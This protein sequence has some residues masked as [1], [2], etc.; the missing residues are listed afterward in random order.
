MR[1]LNHVDIPAEAGF[2]AHINNMGEFQGV[3]HVPLP[4]QPGRVMCPDDVLREPEI[5]TYGPHGGVYGTLHRLPPCLDHHLAAVFVGAGDPAR[6]LL[7]LPSKLPFGML[8]LAITG[9]TPHPD[10][11]PLPVVGD[12][13][14][15]KRA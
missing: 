2:Y 14:E 3:L 6:A 8:A 10:A 5:L 11:A 1:L 15:P 12:E 7:A 9:G 13:E 4:R